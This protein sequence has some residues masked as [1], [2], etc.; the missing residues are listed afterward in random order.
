MSAMEH[1]ITKLS[2]SMDKEVILQ[3]SKRKYVNKKKR[4]SQSSN[5]SVL[6]RNLIDQGKIDNTVP[7]KL[8]FR[9]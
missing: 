9:N 4:V 2:R 5:N 7:V 3:S 1:I 6:S 8:S